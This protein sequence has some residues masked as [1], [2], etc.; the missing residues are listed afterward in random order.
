VLATDSTNEAELTVEACVSV[1]NGYFH[2]LLEFK[3]HWRQLMLGSDSW[4]VEVKS[5]VAAVK[6]SWN[7][8]VVF[9]VRKR[10]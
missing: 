7:V 8:Q 9:R 1:N 4:I 6:L 3:D 10:C 5:C 2:L